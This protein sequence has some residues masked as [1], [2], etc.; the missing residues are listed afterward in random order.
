MCNSSLRV[1]SIWR[2]NIIYILG[3]VQTRHDVLHADHRDS[4]PICALLTSVLLGQR[5]AVYQKL[6]SQSE[7]IAVKPA[8]TRDTAYWL[9]RWRS[10]CWGRRKEENVNSQQTDWTVFLLHTVICMRKTVLNNQLHQVG[11][12]G[13]DWQK[14]QQT[15]ANTNDPTWNPISPPDHRQQGIRNKCNLQPSQ[16]EGERWH[17]TGDLTK[18]DLR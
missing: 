14:L 4:F 9:R 10:T 16:E 5:A 11:W 1:I 12:R 17:N 15:T 7:W 13:P 8:P 6:T 3:V 18:Q 2:S